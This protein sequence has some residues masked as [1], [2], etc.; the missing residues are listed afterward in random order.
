MSNTYDLVGKV[1]IVTGGIGCLIAVMAVLRWG[2]PL[3]NYDG[4]HLRGA[5]AEDNLQGADVVAGTAD[6]GS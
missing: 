6:A 2:G 4:A 3:V 1:A 5:P